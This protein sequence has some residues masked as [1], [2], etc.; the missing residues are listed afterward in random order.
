[1]YISKDFLKIT[2][3]FSVVETLF[4]MG[5]FLLFNF[6]KLKRQDFRSLKFMLNYIPFFM[7]VMIALF[8]IKN[9][10]NSITFR[11]HMYHPATNLLGHTYNTV[12]RLSFIPYMIR[13]SVFMFWLSMFMIKYSRFRKAFQINR[14]SV[15]IVWI[16]FFAMF[17]LEF[18]DGTIGDYW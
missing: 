5:V 15:I 17:F 3:I 4:F 8:V 14:A 1:M 13:W 11:S 9:S 6:A 18:I 16:S 12:Y 2:L 10:I 7:L